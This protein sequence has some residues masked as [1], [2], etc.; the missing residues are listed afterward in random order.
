[1]STNEEFEEIIG[2][3]QPP[4]GEPAAPPPAARTVL[5]A[6]LTPVASPAALAGLLSMG[7]LECRVVGS[8]TG[9]LALREIKAPSDPFA[10]L[11]GQAPEEADQLAATL[12]RLLH[13]D[14]V[15]V[16]SRLAAEG[17][18]GKLSAWRYSGGSAAVSV[19]P[20][21]VL[22]AAD[23]V[24]EDILVGQVD[25]ATLGED[26]AAIPRWR[27]ARMFQRGLRR[28]KQ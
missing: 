6:V 24:V 14:V 19:A 9:A 25:P 26:T 27:A 11:T 7:N 3:L 16:V 20:G 15:L 10:E 4:D 21:L 17:G 1:M 28:R 8:S 13:T 5:A 22:A 23:Q 18:D 12:C 2:R